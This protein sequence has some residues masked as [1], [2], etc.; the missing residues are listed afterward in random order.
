MQKNIE[1]CAENPLDE[2]LNG[3]KLEQKD[4][5]ERSGEVSS[6][7]R[8]RPVLNKITSE[9]SRDEDDKIPEKPLDKRFSI[10]FGISAICLII[11]LIVFIKMRFGQEISQNKGFVSESIVKLANFGSEN[12]LSLE[13]PETSQMSSYRVVIRDLGVIMEKSDIIVKNGKRISEVLFGLD[14]EIQETG[15]ALEEFRHQA[16]GFFFSL[17][18]EMKAITQEIE[19]SQW[20]EYGFLKYF[21]KSN[22]HTLSDSSVN[23]ICKRLG[24]LEKQIPGFQE[25][26]KRVIVAV[27][28]VRDSADNTHGYLIDGER[29]AE[30]SLKKH[31]IGN[32][33]DHVVRKRAEDELLR[34]RIII[35]ML[36]E[37]APNLIK[38]EN[39]LKEY[40]RNIQ[41][42]SKEVKNS[43][44]TAEDLKYLQKA[45]ADLEK[46]H[47]Q[48]SLADKQSISKSMDV[49]DVKYLEEK[50]N[51]EEEHIKF[52][53]EEYK[54]ADILEDANDEDIE[55]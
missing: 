23:F 26:L 38:F 2:R 16:K 31:W 6:T 17:A 7:I 32:I 42:V 51:L 54:P 35:K 39:F 53:S 47:V 43:P 36:K 20:F 45:V 13:I 30:R 40:R 50:Q 52:S 49:F 41:D 9:N 34:V 55:N 33:A 4:P 11:L 22:S 14:K 21:A 28:S 19:N 44:T 25:Q 5:D 37:I 24:M 18:S 10:R 27:Y 29:E 46:H 8:H 15:D 1:N 48:F 3:I 12:L